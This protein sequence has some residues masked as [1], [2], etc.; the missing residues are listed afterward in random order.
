MIALDSLDL[1]VE[2]PALVAADIAEKGIGASLLIANLQANLR[3]QSVNA[4]R[5]RNLF[6]RP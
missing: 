3:S 2:R 5:I 6:S 1:G 4:R